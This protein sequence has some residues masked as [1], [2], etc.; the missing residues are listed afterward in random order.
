MR[1][2]D[3]LLLGNWMNMSSLMEMEEKQF[4]FVLVDYVFAAM[5][6]FSPFVQEKL[7]DRLKS[8]VKGYAYFT[9]QEPYRLHYDPSPIASPYFRGVVGLG[10]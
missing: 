7:V 2:D 3:R 4:D 1:K 9:G 10:W 5:E 6:Y 8:H